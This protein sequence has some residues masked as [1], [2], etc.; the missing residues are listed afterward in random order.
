MDGWCDGD[1]VGIFF[2]NVSTWTWADVTIFGRPGFEP[3]VAGWATG[4]VGGDFVKME[5]DHEVAKGRKD[6]GASFLG[7][8]KDVFAW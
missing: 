5:F 8:G 7:A 3:V 2:G 1:H 4:S 6:V